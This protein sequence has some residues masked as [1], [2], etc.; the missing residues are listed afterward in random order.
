MNN[1]TLYFNSSRSITGSGNIEFNDSNVYVQSISQSSDAFYA[2]EVIINN[3]NISNT[4]SGSYARLFNSNDI[5]VKGNSTITSTSTAG[6]VTLLKGSNI[7]ITDNVTIDSQTNDY[8]IIDGEIVTIGD[9]DG[10][11]SS[12]IY[13][14]SNKAKSTVK[15]NNLYLY[16]GVIKGKKENKREEKE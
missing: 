16:D 15:A 11:V 13:I 10:N 5:Y 12:N 9:K 14:E 7:Y 4:S 3:S 8:F 6:Q 2:K 1:S